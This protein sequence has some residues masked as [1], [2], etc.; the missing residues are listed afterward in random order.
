MDP[1]TITLAVLAVIFIL[2]YIIIATE[3]FHSAAMQ[4]GPCQTE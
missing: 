2:L 4:S 1:A 3:Y